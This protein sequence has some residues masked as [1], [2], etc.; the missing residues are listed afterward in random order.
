MQ[1]L[2]IVLAV[3][4]VLFLFLIF[5]AVRRHPDLKK[6]RG[7]FI[8]HRGFHSREVPENSLEAFRLAAEKGYIIETDIHLTKDGEVVVFHDD[9]LLRM[10]GV[11]AR[12]ENLTLAEIKSYRLK[13]SDAQ[14]PTLREC[15]DTVDGKVPILIE[16]KILKNAFALC[17][18]ADAILSE[19]KGE[20][21]IQ[22]FYPQVLLWYRLHRKE[23]CR[24][25]LSR[26]F[27]GEPI[28]MQMLGCLLYN[29]LSRP[30]FVAYDHTAA[31]HP[32]RRLVTLLGA[33]PV[34]WTVHSQEELEKHRKRFKSYIFE[35]FE[36][37]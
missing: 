1:A 15:L 6:M 3:L 34:C 8:A 26:S 4:L 32:M 23:I 36:P 28:Y 35:H 20:Y 14:I 13:D 12:I 10:C 9:M 29:F 21:Y 2:W 7:R 17:R 24:G 5:P 18:A 11:N 33:Y 27:S 19:Y 30:D 25:Q 16:F 37:Q 31:S 22:S